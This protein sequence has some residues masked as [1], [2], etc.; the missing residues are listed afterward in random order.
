[1]KL[2]PASAA[3]R[4]PLTSTSGLASG[5]VTYTRRTPAL[6]GLNYTVW[7]ST[8][9]TTW[10]RDTGATQTVASTVANVQTVN[11]RLSNVLLTL[12]K[13]FVRVQ[14]AP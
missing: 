6:T 7:T 3:S 5:A 13:L 10:T 11:V 4:N 1:M 8:N 12:P 2:H 14:A 9:L